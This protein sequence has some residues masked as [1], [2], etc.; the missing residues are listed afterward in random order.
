MPGRIK[1]NTRPFAKLEGRGEKKRSSPNIGI[2]GRITLH[3]IALKNKQQ[4]ERKKTSTKKAGNAPTRS[5]APGMLPSE[6]SREREKKTISRKKKKFIG[7][8]ESGPSNFS[9]DLTNE[10]LVW[11]ADRGDDPFRSSR[12]AFGDP[13]ALGGRD[14]AKKK[15]PGKGKL[16]IASTYACVENMLRRRD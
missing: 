6:G 9:R 3:R 12:S 7:N 5:V 2:L 11:A 14:T 4:Y 13:R 1:E 15:T 16:V 8:C 10:A